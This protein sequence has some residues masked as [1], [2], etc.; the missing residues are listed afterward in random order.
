MKKEDLKQ[1]KEVV[2]DSINKNNI[3]I[4]KI[5]DKKNEKLAR[6]VERSF[7][8][9]DKKNDKRSGRLEKKVGG[10]E[11]KVDN[12]SMALKRIERKQN[13]E[14]RTLDEHEKRLT[15]LEKKAI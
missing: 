3:K 6:M 8:A 1:I 2:D 9:S 12:N 4:E 11:E 10:L 7:R 14:T 15:I 5:I 13:V